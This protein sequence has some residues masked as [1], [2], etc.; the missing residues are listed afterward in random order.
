MLVKKEVKR[1]SDNTDTAVKKKIKVR[2][3][4]EPANGVAKKNFQKKISDGKK[5]LSE[6]R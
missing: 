4:E 1:K 6:F 2:G 3:D 5:V